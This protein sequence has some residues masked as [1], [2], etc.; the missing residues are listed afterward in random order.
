[1]VVQA[2]VALQRQV[3]V[4]AADAGEVGRIDARDAERRAA[5]A[6]RLAATLPDQPELAQAL[7]R[8]AQV[9]SPPT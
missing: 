9:A 4:G 6:T 7:L 3:Q 1:M 2:A 5:L 8:E